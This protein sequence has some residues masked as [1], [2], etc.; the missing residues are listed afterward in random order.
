MGNQG[1]QRPAGQRRN[2]HKRAPDVSEI[3]FR[4]SARKRPN[5]TKRRFRKASGPRRHNHG[6]PQHAKNTSAADNELRNEE[7]LSMENGAAVAAMYEEGYRQGYY[8]GGEGRI[9]RLLPSYTVLPDLTVDDVIARGIEQSASLLV[10][11]M[12]SGAVY[13]EIVQALDRR[14][15][16]SLVRLGDGELLTLAHDMVISADQA[17]AWGTFLPYAG[18]ILPDAATRNALIDSLNKASIVGIPESRHPS[19]QGLLFPVLKQLG[20]SCRELKMTTSTVNYALHEQ[21]LFYP[22]LRGRKLLLIGN[23]AAGLANLLASQGFE[24]NG[25]ITPVNGVYDVRRVMKEAASIDFEL[26]LVAAGVAAVLIC[27]AI[28]S[29]LGKVSFDLGHLANRL[30][31]GETP[32]L[33]GL[34]VN[35]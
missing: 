9:C 29:E 32:L 8:E 16:L 25:I 12:P 23:K 17:R 4:G 19:F 33:H 3:G 28:A 22:M 11:L 21:G 20:I 15:P 7:Q 14:L 31:N 35:G 1:R 26:A 6:M 2:F 13:T 34:E 27:T 5:K 18:V 24:V 10:P 30:E